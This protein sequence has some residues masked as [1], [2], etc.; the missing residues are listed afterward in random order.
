MTVAWGIPA[1]VSSTTTSRS[2]VWLF[3]FCAD[4]RRRNQQREECE[5]GWRVHFVNV[6]A[7]KF[8]LI[9]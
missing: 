9:L 4:E 5:R 6:F 8:G 2:W 7:L 1:P 3:A